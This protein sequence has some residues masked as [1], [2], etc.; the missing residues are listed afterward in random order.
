MLLKA[1]VLPDEVVARLKP[2]EA[3]EYLKAL[4]AVAQSNRE[5]KFYGMFPNE[6]PFRRELY[7]KH[8]QFFRLGAIHRERLFMAGN[9]VGKSQ[10]GMFEATA[11][12]TGCYP[13]WWEGRRFDKPIRAWVAGKDTTTT[14]DILLTGLFGEIIS[15]PNGTKSMDG[16]GMVPKRMIGAITWRRGIDLIDRARVRHFDAKGNFDGWSKVGFKSYEMGRGSFEGTEQEMVLLDEEPPED[17]YSECLVRTMTTGGIVMVLFTPM[18][19]LSNV[20]KSFM[21]DGSA[22]ADERLA[23]D[24]DI[25]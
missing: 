12:L 19:G 18:A 22:M 24:P 8:V 21:G 25:E 5:N 10:G 14:R 11:H 4:E 20:V 3:A 7:P 1:P 2:N 13:D 15:N 6:G 23:F 16:M 9:R 17:V